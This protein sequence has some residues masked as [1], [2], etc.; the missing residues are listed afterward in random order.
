MMEKHINKK[1]S[2]L[3]FAAV[4][5]LSSVDAASSPWR[6]PSLWHHHRR[7]LVRNQNLSSELRRHRRHDDFAAS[8]AETASAPT[9]DDVVAAA[10]ASSS[11]IKNAVFCVRGGGEGNN[12]PCIGIDLGKSIP[13]LLSV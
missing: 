8:T 9:T 7:P 12:G 3:V 5:S 11:P 6:L 10:A 4:A 1:W 13:F 2:L